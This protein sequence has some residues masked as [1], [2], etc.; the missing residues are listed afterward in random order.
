VE[1]YPL[2]CWYVAATS[3]EVGRELLA[4]RLLGRA[5]LLYRVRSGEVVALRDR[6]AHRGL[7]LT[8]GWLDDDEVV[9]A[10]HGFRYAASGRCVRVP[11]QP[12]VPDGVRVRSFPVRDDGVFVWV[13][14][15]DP[16][17]A[18]WTPR[19]RL[20]WLHDD[21]WE[22]FGGSLHVAANYLLLHEN[23]LDL[24]HVPFVHPQMGPAGYRTGAPP[25]PV[26]IEVG[27]RIVSYTRT[28]PPAPLV[29]WQVE[30]TG[31]PADRPYPQREVGAFLSPAVHVNHIDVLGAAQP[32]AAPDYERVYVGLV[33]PETPTSTHLHWRVAR[34]HGLGD[35]TITRALRRAS[36]DAL[37]ADAEIF[38][39]IQANAGDHAAEATV[40]ADLAAVTARRIVAAML[41]EERGPAGRPPDAYSY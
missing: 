20:P 39:A 35:D 40:A 15:G 34:N 9:C 14:L 7:P 17:V 33:T 30:V 12:R 29:A 8:R 18:G 6:C 36:E 26:D 28:F 23:A 32:P 27:E 21:G 2:N 22:V 5:V 4:R 41:V 16:A 10:Y 24:T 19:P 3:D 37:R 1:N 25:P 38:A 11:S 13:W 31:L